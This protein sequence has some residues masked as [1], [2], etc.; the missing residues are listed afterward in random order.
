MIALDVENSWSFWDLSFVSANFW[1]SSIEIQALQSTKSIFDDIY[2]L[3]LEH[4]IST[5][6]RSFEN[7]SR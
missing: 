5:F 1:F 3:E 7:K 4:E 2:R 6:Q